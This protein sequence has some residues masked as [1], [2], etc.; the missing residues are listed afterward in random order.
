MLTFAKGIRTAGRRNWNDDLMEDFETVADDRGCTGHFSADA[1]RLALHRIDLH[2]RSGTGADKYSDRSA[3]R[4]C[5]DYLF[6]AEWHHPVVPGFF[7]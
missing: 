3:G 1:F 4:G 2:I 6:S 7:D 5:S